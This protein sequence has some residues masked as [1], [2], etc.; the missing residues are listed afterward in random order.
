MSSATGGAGDVPA[1]PGQT[2]PTLQIVERDYTAIADKLGALGPLAEKLGFTVKGVT[3]ELGHE[4]KRLA[5][6]NGVMLGGAADGRPALDT[7][8]KLAEAILTLQR[9][10][11]RRARR[12]RLPKPGEARRK[13]AGRP[14]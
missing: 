2:M 6:M 12:A 4:V 7:D 8:V 3:Y 5:G 13:E 1:I 10:H 9:H 11:E 14:G